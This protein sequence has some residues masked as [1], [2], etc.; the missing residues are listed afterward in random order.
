MPTN[1]FTELPIWI[2]E[3]GVSTFGAEEVQEFGLRRT[4]ELLRGRV[5]R[6]HWYSLYDL[7]RAWPATTPAVIHGRIVRTLTVT[8][9][10]RVPSPRVAPRSNRPFSYVSAM[11]R[12]SI[13]ISAT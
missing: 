7:P 10:P 4:A 13:F 11:L 5:G 12:P 3:V 9:S 2:S 6:V 8:S 1:S